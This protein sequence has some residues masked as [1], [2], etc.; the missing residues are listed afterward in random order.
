VLL[1]AV[2]RNTSEQRKNVTP[3]KYANGSVKNGRGDGLCRML[4]DAHFF[5]LIFLCLTLV[6][7]PSMVPATDT[8]AVKVK[9]EGFSRSHGPA[10]VAIFANKSETAD[11][12]GPFTDIG[13]WAFSQPAESEMPDIEPAMAKT[14]KITA[15]FSPCNAMRQRAGDPARRATK[16][17]YLF[18]K[19]L[20]C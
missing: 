15:P 16:A 1:H 10:H 17:L 12:T 9:A 19:S 14:K 3:A 13:K 6:I 7:S 20:L 8:A 18:H 11:L 2:K 5:G 4:Q